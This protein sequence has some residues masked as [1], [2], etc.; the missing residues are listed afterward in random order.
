MALLKKTHYTICLKWDCEKT[1]L[2]RIFERGHYCELWMGRIHFPENDFSRS[3]DCSND[4]LAEVFITVWVGK[5]QFTAQ[6]PLGEEHKKMSTATVQIS[7]GW[8]FSRGS[9]ISGIPMAL[10]SI[11]FFGKTA[12]VTAMISHVHHCFDHSF[13]WASRMLIS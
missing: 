9:Q 6:F 10:I 12:V 11:L 7:T 4:W 2:S 1:R 8:F 13:V 5:P 3:N